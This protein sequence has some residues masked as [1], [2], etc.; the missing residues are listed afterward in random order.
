[1]KEAIANTVI[2]GH[3]PTPEFLADCEAVVTGWMTHAEA[4]ARSL[5]RALGME[6]ETVASPGKCLPIESRSGDRPR[7]RACF[8][9]RRRRRRHDFDLKPDA[10]VVLQVGQDGK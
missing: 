9:A 10:T 3:V 2:E 4:R 7:C 1:M 8:F 5:A 6:T